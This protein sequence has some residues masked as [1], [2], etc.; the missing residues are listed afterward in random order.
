LLRALGL[1]DRGGKPDAYAVI[2]DGVALPRVLPVLDA[3]RAQGVAVLMHAS[4]HAG[5]G[6]KSQ[7]KKADASG[8]RYALVFG[9]DELA[10]G[11]VAVKPLRQPDAPQRERALADA[12]IWATELRDA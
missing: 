1:S 4:G 9:A 10:R 7:F 12:A 11:V 8:A 5:G 3:L 2:G 6:M